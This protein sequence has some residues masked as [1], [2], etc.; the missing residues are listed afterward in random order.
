[1]K[2][3]QEAQT[4]F[5]AAKLSESLKNENEVLE[6]LSTRE[7]QVVRRYTHALRDRILTALINGKTAETSWDVLRKRLDSRISD[8]TRSSFKQLGEE[9]NALRKQLKNAVEKSIQIKAYYDTKAHGKNL[10]ILSPPSPRKN[11]NRLKTRAL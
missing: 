3:A 6:S 1:M 4:A 8:L 2:L 9:C 5:K 7:D 10:P 11:R